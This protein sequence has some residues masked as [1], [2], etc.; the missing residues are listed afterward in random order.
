MVDFRKLE[1]RITRLYLKRGL[2]L[3]GEAQNAWK[4]VSPP[5]G[6]TPFQTK[7]RHILTESASEFQ[8]SAALAWFESAIKIASKMGKPGFDSLH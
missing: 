1:I 7:P 8:V 4:I 3:S 2:T 6:Q 5:K